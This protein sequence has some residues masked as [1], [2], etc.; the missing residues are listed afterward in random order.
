MRRQVAA[1]LGYDEEED[2]APRLY[3]RGWG[4]TAEEMINVAEENGVPIHRDEDLAEVLASLE[5]GQVI[6]EDLF[7]AVAEVLAY[8]YEQNNSFPDERTS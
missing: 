8:V 5:V 2:P 6:P 1:A 7:V 3:A 4:Y